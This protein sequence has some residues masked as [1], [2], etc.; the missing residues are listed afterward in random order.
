[1]SSCRSLMKF[2]DVQNYLWMTYSV[3]STTLLLNFTR[4]SDSSYPHLPF[5]AAHST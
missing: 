2:F 1:M 5:S 4:M 3:P